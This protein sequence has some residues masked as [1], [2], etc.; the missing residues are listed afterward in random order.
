MEQSMR[1]YQMAITRTGTRAVYV[2][3]IAF[4]A[5]AVAGT[6]ADSDSVSVPLVLVI[7]VACIGLIVWGEKTWIKMG[8]EEVPEGYIDRHHLG[9]RALRLEDIDCFESRKDLTVN[10]VYAIRRTN[11]MGIPIQGLVQ[12]RRVLWNG[13]ETR[14]IVRILNEGLN[15][16]RRER[17]LVPIGQAN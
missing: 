17:N 7:T 6:L 15:E 1:Y 13:A 10:R 12:G 16:R 3:G 5:I 9:S 8:L 14:D 2:V 4:M 11:G